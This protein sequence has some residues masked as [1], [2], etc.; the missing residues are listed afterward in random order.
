[1]GSRCW[2]TASRAADHQAVAALEAPDAAAGAHVDVVDALGGEFFGAADVVDVVGV[3][4]VDED[5]AGFEMRDDL[6]D[7]VVDGCGG[8]HEPDGAGFG[9][10]AEQVF[11]GRGGGE[12]FLCGHLLDDLRGTIE[13]DALVA[14]CCE[15][16]QPCCAGLPELIFRLRGLLLYG[17]CKVPSLHSS[18]GLKRANR[19]GTAEAAWS[20]R[21]S[22]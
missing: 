3:A 11:D 21:P 13:A 17:R 22:H 2:T 14:V 12:D 10:F 9:E 6:G 4:A 19:G 5:V 20:A 8:D 16:A 18:D 15:A 1:M 7:G